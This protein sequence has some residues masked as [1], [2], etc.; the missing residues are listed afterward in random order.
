M[1]SRSSTLPRTVFGILGA[2]ILAIGTLTACSAGDDTASDS[3]SAA[4]TDKCT[5]SGSASDSIN[6]GGDFDT[7]P[8][9]EFTSPLSVDRTERTVV[10]EGDGKVKAEQGA[11]VAASYTVYNGTTGEQV[12]STGF[13][14]EGEAVG[15][16][17]DET[18]FL[19]GIV[20]ALNCSV[21]GDRVVAVVP[22][23]DAFGDEGLADLEIGADDAMVFV[24][25]VKEVTEA[26]DAAADMKTVEPDASGMPTVEF[27]ADGVPAVTIPEGDAPKN[28]QLA[29][30][31][32]GDGDVVSEGD[33]VE[34]NYTGINWSTGESFDSSWE[35]GEPASFAT[36][37]VIPGFGS[38]LVGQ[39]V[40]TQLVVVIPAEY[41]YGS[42]GNANAGISG[43]DTIVFVVEILGTSAA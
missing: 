30:L 18:Q 11:T 38:A 16:I 12:D 40:G 39:A 31:K 21:A 15:F 35:R 19:A 28:L 9:V 2:T 4:I 33:T 6:V 17:V 36:N 26:I 42:G 27:G 32:Q 7:E 41:G 25:D 14:A 3:G 5:D 43:T 1:S 8:T 37:A 23:A 13:G 34:L 22:P 24:I 20:R 29:I 10:I